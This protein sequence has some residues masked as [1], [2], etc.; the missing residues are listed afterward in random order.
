MSKLDDICCTVLRNLLSAASLK[1][2]LF[3]FFGDRNIY[4]LFL[5]NLLILLNYVI[6]YR[7]N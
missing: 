2:K 3:V 1:T 6:S 7:A 5:I 4:A